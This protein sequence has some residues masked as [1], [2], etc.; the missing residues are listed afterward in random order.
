MDEANAEQ[1]MVLIEGRTETIRIVVGVVLAALYAVLALLPMSGFVGAGGVTSLLSFAI[2]IA[3]LFG[4]LLGPTRGFVFGLIAGMLAYIVTLPFGTSV[5]IWLPPT[6]LGPAVAGLFTGLAMKKTTNIKGVRLPGPIL[7]ALFLAAIIVL[8]EIPNYSAWWFMTPY[9]LALIIVLLL[10]VRSI[11]FN[12]DRQGPLR[13]LQLLPYTFI[14]AM[15]D[16]SMMAMGSVYILALDPAIFGFVI[17]PLVLLERGLAAIVGA[18]IASVVLGAFRNAVWI[19]AQVSSA[20][21]RV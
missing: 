6:I 17:F 3:P 9:L 19:E 13:Y 18:V 15:L 12:P 4:L 7:T 8:Y 10:Q 14:G 2:I 21:P 20:E 11:E 16:H 5:Y 1:D